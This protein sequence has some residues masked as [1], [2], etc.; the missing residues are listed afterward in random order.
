MRSKSNV[1]TKSSGHDT[2]SIRVTMQ[3][4]VILLAVGITVL[5]E[6]TGT[7][8]GTFKFVL[9][10]RQHNTMQYNFIVSV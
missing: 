7:T 5:V 10:K 6:A 1:I 8:D 2:V 3:T 9:V 4:A